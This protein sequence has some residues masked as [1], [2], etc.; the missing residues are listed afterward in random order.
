MG[1]AE[2]RAGDEENARGTL[3]RKRPPHPPQSFKTGSLSRAEWL[4]LLLTEDFARGARTVV[5]SRLKFSSTFFKRWR[6]QGRVAL[7]SAFLFL[8]F[9]LRLRNQRKAAKALIHLNS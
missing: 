6:G 2:K 9:S 8:S 4:R 3:S 1:N 5:T 7:V